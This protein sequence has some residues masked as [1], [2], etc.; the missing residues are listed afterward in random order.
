M[1]I[2]WVMKVTDHS[3]WNTISSWQALY[4]YDVRTVVLRASS[5]GSYKDPKFEPYY[6]G[7]KT[8]GMRVLAY[9]VNHPLFSAA[10]NIANYL[11]AVQGFALDGYPVLDCQLTGGMSDAVIRDRTKSMFYLLKNQFSGVINYTAKWW[12]DRYMGTAN[13]W[14]RE[15]PLWVANYWTSLTGNLW[16]SATS[17]AGYVPADY[18]GQEPFM[19]QFSS[20]G[21]LPL[22][23]PGNMD[24][25]VAYPRFVSTLFSTVPTL[26]TEC[27]QMK[28]LYGMNVRKSPGGEIIG[29]VA[30]GTVVDVIGVGG[31]N[32]WIE[33]PQGWIAVETGGKVY[34]TKV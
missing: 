7:A 30:A 33:T 22:A 6:Y 34:C 8:V 20:N 28:T 26:P 9:H 24:K 13:P 4:D 27:L 5:G 31:S 2:H 18:V 10:A 3:Y 15:F 25:N 11:G 23:S 29:S 16:P 12:W 14:V 21:I 32:S 1:A 19:W 17:Y